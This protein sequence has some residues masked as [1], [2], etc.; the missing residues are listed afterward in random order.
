MKPEY[1]SQHKLIID[2]LSVLKDLELIYLFGSKADGSDTSGSDWD[3]AVLCK[4]A[5]EATDRWQIA[6]S[7]ANEL[8]A[9]VDLIDLQQAS[10]VLQM[11]IVNK[12]LLLQGDKA[13]ADIYET[14]VYSMYGRLQES[15]NEIIE[16]FIGDIKNG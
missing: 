16:Q 14:K 12:G 5:L 9:D 2:H 3:I 10:T 1:N 13:S 7:I 8:G 15:R 11:E 4:Q 6:Q